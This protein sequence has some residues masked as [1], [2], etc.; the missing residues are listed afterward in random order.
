MS[1]CI[2]LTRTFVKLETLDE[3]HRSDLQKISQ[4]DRIS[5][6]SPILKLN[7]DA[8]FDK[9]LKSSAESSQITF[10]VRTLKDDKIVGSTR[11]YDI[12][13][14]HKR[15]AIGYTWY[16]PEVWGSSVNAECKLL[17]LRYAFETL[18]MNRV[19]FFIDARNARSRA[20]VKKLGATEEGILRQHIILEDG[21]TRDTVVCSILKQEWATVLSNLEKRI[22]LLTLRTH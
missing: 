20:A 1:N 3:T 2:I 7:F 13:L 22:Q 18:Q 19:E 14:K 8:W 9:A 15:L 12:D 16:V 10:V 11:F 17:L 6:Y 21:F 4:D 5:A